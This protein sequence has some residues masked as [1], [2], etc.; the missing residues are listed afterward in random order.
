MHSNREFDMPA[1]GSLFGFSRTY[2][3][4]SISAE[5]KAKCRQQ[6]V[7]EFACAF[8]TEA[9]LENIE[10]AWRSAASPRKLHFQTDPITGRMP[11]LADRPRILLGVGTRVAAMSLVAHCRT[12]TARMFALDYLCHNYL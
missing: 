4:L 7:V 12:I 5:L 1:S 8:R 6:L 3:L 9:F 11:A 2:S 10:D